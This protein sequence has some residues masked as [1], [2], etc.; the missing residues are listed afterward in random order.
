VFFYA[1]RSVGGFV[2]LERYN[3]SLKW[4]ERFHGC[5]A[6][7]MILVLLSWFRALVWD[8]DAV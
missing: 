2:F 8:N 5:Y 1:C 6:V 4:S 7:G 3:R